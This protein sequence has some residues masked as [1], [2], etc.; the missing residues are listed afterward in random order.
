LKNLNSE[1]FSIISGVNIVLPELAE[2]YRTFEFYV[3]LVR[4]CRIA[5]LLGF[6]QVEDQL[7]R[8]S[9]GLHLISKKGTNQ[10]MK[11]QKEALFD[12]RNINYF[13]DVQLE[14]YRN[15]E[16]IIR[17]ASKSIQQV[18]DLTRHWIC[19]VKQEL[20]RLKDMAL[21]LKQH[22]ALLSEI[23][24]DLPDGI[25]SVAA[26][27]PP[28]GMSF[29]QGKRVKKTHAYLVFAEEH[30]ICIPK[31]ISKYRKNNKVMNPNKFHYRQIRN[32]TTSHSII[33]GSQLKIALQEKMIKISAPPNLIEVINDYLELILSGRPYTVGSD[34]IIINIEEN[35]PNKS[36]YK[37]ATTKFISTI[38]ERL[39]GSSIQTPDYAPFAT[40]SIKE[41]RRKIS[42]LQKNIRELDHQARSRYVD[43]DE[44]Q[45][46]R[47]Q[48]KDSMRSLQDNMNHLVDK[49]VGGHLAKEMNHNNWFIN[50]DDLLE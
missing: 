14:H 48:L 29:P 18:S 38:R 4:L 46:Q 39:F 22:Y 37:N 40:S 41:L 16:S 5:G 6:P 12:L 1:Y 45:S 49:S 23:S 31:D 36:G 43:Y 3:T 30:L 21:P 7:E 44:Y 11:I 34:K 19:E 42:S 2:L 8:C 47:S 17:S 33:K 10:L 35:S 25:S 50:P 27:I 24:R 28:V 26:L 15:A 13:H 9:N 20:I 32:I